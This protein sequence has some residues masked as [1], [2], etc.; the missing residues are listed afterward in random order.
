MELHRVHS[1]VQIMQTLMSSCMYSLAHTTIGQSKL[2]IPSQL[3][4]PHRT[5]QLQ[6]PNLGTSQKIPRQQR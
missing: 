3:L 5:Q 1:I 6:D 2:G 4:Q